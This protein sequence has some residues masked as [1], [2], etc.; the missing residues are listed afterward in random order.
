MKRSRSV[1]LLV[2]AVMAVLAPLS[3]AAYNLKAPFAP[4]PVLLTSI[5]QSADVEMAKAIINRLKISFTMDSLVK[6]QGLASSN[7][8]TLIIVIGGSS[9]G[10]G[11]AGISADAELERTK[12]LP[13]DHEFVTPHRMGI[14]DNPCPGRVFCCSLTT[15]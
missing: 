12:A 13:G 1:L 2:A 10:L 7:A 6:A 8:K 15:D 4:Q 11:A 3:L 9:K 14:R 5:G